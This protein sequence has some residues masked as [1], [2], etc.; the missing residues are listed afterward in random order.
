MNELNNKLREQVKELKSRGI[1]YKFICELL[2]DIKTTSFYSWVSG[3]YD[4]GY[5]KTIKLQKIVNKIKE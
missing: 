2:G 4:F 5:Q 3:N 1:N